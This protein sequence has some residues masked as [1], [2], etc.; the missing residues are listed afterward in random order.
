MDKVDITVAFPVGPK[1]VHK[2]YLQECL[3]SIRAQTKKPYE[4]IIVDDAANLDEELDTF[5]EL[6][7]E[8]TL[9]HKFP[10]HF[11]ICAGFNACV[12]LSETSWVYLMAADDK[13][14]PDA[15]E[16]AERAL[17]RHKQQ[18][19]WYF[20]AMLYDNPDL[21]G[22]RVITSWPTLVGV[23]HK[24]LWLKTGGVPVVSEMT[25]P[26]HVLKQLLEQKVPGFKYFTIDAPGEYSYYARFHKGSHTETSGRWGPYLDMLHIT[27][28]VLEFWEPPEWTEGLR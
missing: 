27:E 17:L 4:V 25:A 7:E 20:P 1:E 28:K 23:V 3:E 10:W 12:S 22:G 24:D 6:A 15:L 18:L 8:G 13:L 14:M 9:I 21:P 19:G 11:G 16:K 2:Q 5:Y 26:D